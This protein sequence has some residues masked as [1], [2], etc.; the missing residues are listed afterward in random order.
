MDVIIFGRKFAKVWLWSVIKL[1][2]GTQ[3]IMSEIFFFIF[4]I[5]NPYVAWPRAVSLAAVIRVV[6]QRLGQEHCVTPLITAAKKTSWGP[7]LEA[8]G[9]YRAR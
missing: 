7:F 1:L 5:E 3:I 4:Y 9:N 2:N 8:P 6:T